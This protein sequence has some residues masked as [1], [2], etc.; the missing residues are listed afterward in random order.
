MGKS[1]HLEWN[2]LQLKIAKLLNTLFSRRVTLVI[3]VPFLP[4]RFTLR[5]QACGLAVLFSAQ[6][7]RMCNLT[8][9]H[10]FSLRVKTQ[11]SIPT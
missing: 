2:Q 6:S 9:L 8:F 11:R 10:L 4:T 1:F 7:V 5:S 3:S